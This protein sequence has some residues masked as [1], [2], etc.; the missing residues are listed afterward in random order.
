MSIFSTLVQSLPTKPRSNHMFE[1]ISHYFSR[2]FPF[3]W[4]E[5]TSLN[6]FLGHITPFIDRAGFYQ[7]NILGIIRYGLC[8]V[9]LAK[10]MFKCCETMALFTS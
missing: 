10:E 4:G 5:M 8:T 1:T 9:G 7:K 3:L 6:A 2:G